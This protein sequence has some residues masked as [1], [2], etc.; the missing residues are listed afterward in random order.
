MRTH[1]APAGAAASTA[2]NNRGPLR[3]DDLKE[4]ITL[5]TDSSSPLRLHDVPS[6]WR[7]PVLV[8]AFS[9][10]NDAAESATAAARVLSRS[11]P[12]K[13]L[14]AIE[15]E[16]FYHFGLTRPE[17]RFRQDGSGIRDVHWPTTDFVRSDEPALARDVIVG[18]GIEPHLKWQTFCG[19]ILELA[20][21]A[22]VSLVIT[23]GALLADVPHTRPIRISGVASD[24]E[25]RGRFQTTPT[26]YEGPTGILG[27][28]NDACR[29]A[30]LPAVSLWAN[31]PHYISEVSNPHAVLALV[32]RVLDFLEWRAD[33]SE[34]T[35]AAAEFD[36]QLAR[37]L[38]QKPEVAKYVRELEERQAQ[39]D[40]ADEPAADELPSA[41][42]LIR[43]AEQFL[44][45][46]QGDGGTQ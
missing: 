31:V 18:V 13:P 40:P 22:Q 17:V 9:G 37:I 14:A 2:R 23:L 30:G 26:R 35:E 38:E 8:V 10:W 34:L 43:E 3:H 25:L 45:R 1:R 29:R 28:L 4:G 15:P 11:W 44:R 20:H 32:R 16:E 19:H 5:M 7:R 42:D 24:P 36:R 33:L 39:A 27:I 21:R 46:Q 6:E 41:A 12:S